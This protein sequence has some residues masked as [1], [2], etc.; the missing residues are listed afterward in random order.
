MQAV[1][2]AHV[3]SRSDRSEG[4]RDWLRQHCPELLMEGLRANVILFQMTLSPVV[5]C[6]QEVYVIFMVALCNRAEHYIF[7]LW[8]L[9]FF[10]A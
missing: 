7:A 9:S 5:C 4:M 2:E 3:A 1:D 10:L 8:F 6:Y